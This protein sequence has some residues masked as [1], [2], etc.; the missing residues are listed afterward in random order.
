LL[1]IAELNN[2]SE[3]LVAILGPMHGEMFQT[4]LDV[5]ER[6]IHVTR[7]PVAYEELL[8]RV[9]IHHLE[10]DWLLRSFVDELPIST[11]Y[12]MTKRL[13]DIVGSLVGLLVLTLVYPWLALAILIESGRP[14]L[15]KQRRSGQGGR[16][17]NVV[18]FRT[19][20]QDAE[21]DGQALWT[22]QTRELQVWVVSYAKLILMSSPN[23]GMSSRER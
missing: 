10:S 15:F 9:P 16:L 23:S 18:K 7:M 17:Y 21:A 22:N 1:E 3:L 11:F 4:L 19:M 20:R 5:Q 13:L 12:L 14:I 2:V 8:G 6:G